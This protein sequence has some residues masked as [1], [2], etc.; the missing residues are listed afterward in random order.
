MY[1]TIHKIFFNNTFSSNHVF[2][3]TWFAYLKP[4]YFIS[5]YNL[6]YLQYEKGYY[7]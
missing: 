6:L 4:F 7:N 3:N 5:H 2:N 1:L